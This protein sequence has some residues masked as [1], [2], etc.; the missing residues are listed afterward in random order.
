M[1]QQ[2]ASTMALDVTQYA[3]DPKVELQRTSVR[4]ALDALSETQER[5]V[6]M[7]CVLLDRLKPVLREPDPC[8]TGESNPELPCGLAREIDEH[9]RAL[10]QLAHRVSST[11]ERLEL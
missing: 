3:S 9:A 8:T 11:L 10:G 2:E 5:L 4:Q 7:C 1:I 6:N